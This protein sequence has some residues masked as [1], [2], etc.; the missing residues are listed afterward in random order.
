LD[1]E[2]PKLS[3]IKLSPLQGNDPSKRGVIITWI[4]DKEATAQLEYGSGVTPGKY[5]QKSPADP[6]FTTSHTIII[7]DLEPGT[8]YHFRLVSKDRRGNEGRSQDFTM[9]TQEKEESIFQ[10]ILKTLEETFSWV[11]KVK[12]FIVGQFNKMFK[13]K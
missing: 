4:T 5:D 13:G 7:S 9:L 6:N 11:G 12:D 2:G 8:T 3:E 10:L 1:I